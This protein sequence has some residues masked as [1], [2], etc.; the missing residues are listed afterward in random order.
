MYIDM[1][2]I[3]MTV[4]WYVSI[5]LWENR[6][7]APL[8]LV[9]RHIELG[10][11]WYRMLSWI[12]V[13]IGSGNLV[14]CLMPVGGGEWGG[15]LPLW[16]SVGKRRGFAPHFRH[17]D[18]LFCP[19][20]FDH[21]YH[22]IQISLGLISKAPH[23]QYVDDLFAPKLS[24]SIVLFRSCWVPFWTSS[25]APL[26]ILTRSA[27]PRPDGTRA[28]TRTKADHADVLSLNEPLETNLSE[29]GIKAI[30]FSVNKIFENAVCKILSVFRAQRTRSR[31]LFIF[32]TVL[33]M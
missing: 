26:L 31:P 17:L 1:Y 22:F 30:Q 18:D 6:I 25:G 24:K 33:L 12:L 9:R 14:C 8:I 19:P 10:P 3:V 21:V 20:K 5:I 7:I 15:P 16:E 27:P 28:I 11:W 13:N 29:F 32:I 2:C 23:F 4:L